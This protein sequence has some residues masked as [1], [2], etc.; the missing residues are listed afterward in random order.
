MS[1]ASSERWPNWWQPIASLWGIVLIYAVYGLVNSVIS[2]ADGT[3]IAHDDAKLNVLTQHFSA[4]YLPDNPPLYEWILFLVQMITGPSLISFLIVKYALFTLMGVGTF[5]ALRA[6]IANQQT[7]T[8]AS[9]QGPAIGN[10]PGA[11]AAFAAIGLLALYQIGWNAH[12]AFTHSLALMAVVPFFVWRVACLVHRRSLINYC[13][14]GIFA[15]LGMLSKYSFVATLLVVVLAVAT[16]KRAREKISTQWLALSILCFALIMGPHAIAV[17]MNSLSDT[18]SL[19]QDR[20]GAEASWFARVLAGLPAA[21]WAAVTFFAPFALIALFLRAPRRAVSDIAGAGWAGR[22]FLSGFIVLIA[23]VVVMGA[24]DFAERYAIAFL[25][26]A[27]FGLIVLLARHELPALKQKR[28]L[29][30]LC[31]MVLA[32][33][34]FRLLPVIKPGPPFCG[35]CAQW[36]PFEHLTDEISTSI[37]VDMTLVGFDAQTAGNLRRAFARNRVVSSHLPDYW[38]PV[39]GKKSPACK[40][41]W[42]P[43]LSPPPPAEVLASFSSYQQRTITASW[44]VP[45]RQ[46]DWRQTSWHVVDIP[47]DNYAYS[48]LCFA[49]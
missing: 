4:Q 44:S 13:G 49:S 11:I 32:N 21:L 17:L 39:A 23:F 5:L 27:Y 7:G 1:Q 48:V 9:G 37:E 36:V 47:T 33:P 29:F 14:A 25:L 15:G 22:L 8:A 45:G 16:D 19:L 12:Q 34:A 35:N 41:I 20:F 26:P 2:L 3:A 6:I 38:P 43:D 42:S 24:K 18:H 28:L 31:A 10:D 46:K 40:F 30:I